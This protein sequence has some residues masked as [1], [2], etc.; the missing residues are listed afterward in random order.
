M[1]TCGQHLRSAFDEDGGAILDIEA[2]LISTL[3]PTGAFV[4][5]RLQKG[6]P[7]DAIV[8]SL[9]RETGQNPITVDRDVREFIDELNHN[10]LYPH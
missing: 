10:H 9:V 7:I 2:G 5:R 8:S 1:E 3:N 4:W 6:E